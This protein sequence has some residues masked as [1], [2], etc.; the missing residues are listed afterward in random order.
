MHSR[1]LVLNFLSLNFALNIFDFSSEQYFSKKRF[2]KV[3]NQMMIQGY[4]I[5]CNSLMSHWQW[6]TEMTH[7]V[8]LWKKELGESMADEP[9]LQPLYKV[10]PGEKGLTP[11]KMMSWTTQPTMMSHRS[12]LWFMKMTSYAGILENGSKNQSKFVKI[13]DWILN[14]Y[15]EA[16][17]QRT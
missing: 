7:I 8:S 5:H 12:W 16:H 13:R 4:N 15:R 1:T 17:L 3:M 10:L 9:D 14:I 6:V 11:N 2:H